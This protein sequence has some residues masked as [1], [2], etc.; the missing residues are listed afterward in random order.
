MLVSDT[1]YFMMYQDAAIRY[2]GLG[3]PGITEDTLFYLTL[4]AWTS[5]ALK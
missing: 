5:M 4:L 2:K 3:P 1:V